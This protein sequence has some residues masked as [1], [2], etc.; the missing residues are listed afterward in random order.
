M[1]LMFSVSFMAI[2]VK[3]LLKLFPI[4]TGSVSILLPFLVSMIFSFEL[5]L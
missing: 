5:F 3:K 2:V 4:V 1:L